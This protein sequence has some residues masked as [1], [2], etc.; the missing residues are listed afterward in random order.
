MEKYGII[1]GVP[2]KCPTFDFMK[3]ENDCV[4]MISFYIF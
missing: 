4:Y 2:K 1:P 3:V